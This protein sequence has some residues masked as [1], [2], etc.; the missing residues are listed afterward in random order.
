MPGTIGKKY[1]TRQ[2]R[3]ARAGARELALSRMQA[4]AGAATASGNVGVK[5]AVSN[6]VWG[7]QATGFLAAGTAIRRL[8]DEH[9]LPDT[10]PRPAFTLTLDS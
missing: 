8:A 5:V 2:T 3:A 1:L 9:R 6:H 10:T 7:E 4:A